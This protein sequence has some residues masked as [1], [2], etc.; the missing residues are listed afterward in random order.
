M[1]VDVLLLE[2]M[3]SKQKSQP[4]PPY[5]YLIAAKKYF[6]SETLVDATARHLKAN[7]QL[8]PAKEAIQV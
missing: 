7:S 3:L 1:F 2:R 8:I 5:V 6:R 4:C